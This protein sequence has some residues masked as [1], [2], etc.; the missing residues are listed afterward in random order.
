MLFNVEIY[1][2]F[3]VIIRFKKIP[4]VCDCIIEMLFLRLT[5]LSVFFLLYEFN[6]NI[7]ILYIIN[8]N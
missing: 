5:I 3:I 7:S 6:T 4:E 1:I 8:T 2:T